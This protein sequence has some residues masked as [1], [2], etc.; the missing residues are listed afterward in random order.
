MALRFPENPSEGIAGAIRWPAAILML[1][2]SWGALVAAERC[3]WPRV[4]LRLLDLSKLCARA[5]RAMLPQ[6]RTAVKEP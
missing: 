1:W 5:A 4:A 6:R 3:P 2:G